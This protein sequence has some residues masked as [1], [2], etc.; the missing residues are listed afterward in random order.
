MDVANLILLPRPR[1]VTPGEG[2]FLFKKGMSIACP[3]RPEALRHVALILQSDI[4]ELTGIDTALAD[5]EAPRNPVGQIVFKLLSRDRVPAQGYRIQIAP[6][7]VTIEASYETGA[8]YA[9]MTLR[10][11]LRQCGGELPGLM[12][13]DYPDFPSRGVML[14]ISRDRVPTMDTLYQLVDTLA[15]LKINHLELYTEHTFAYRNHREVW[16]QSSPMTADEIRGLDYYCHKRFIEL[17]PNQNSF[18]HLHRW[19]KHPKYRDLAECPDGFVTPWSETRRDPFSLNPLDPRS[20]ELVKELFSELLPN[21]TSRRFN[22]GC[23]ETFDLGQGRSKDECDK[24]G[25]GRVYVDF[26]LK[27]YE[28]VRENNRTMHFWGDIVLKHKALIPAL[29]NDLVALVWGY[30]ADHPFDAQCPKFVEASIPFFVCPGTSTWNAIAGRTDNM[31]ANMREATEQGIRHG[32]IGCLI[33][34]WGDN[35]HWQPLPVSY[36]PY[37]IGAAYSWGIKANR[38]SDLLPAIDMHVFRDRAGVMAAAARDLGNAYLHVDFPIHNASALFK[39][40]HQSSIADLLDKIPEGRLP[41]AREHIEDA[42]SRMHKA[43]IQRKDADA[44]RDEFSLAANMM[45]H[46]CARGTATL[47]GK[48]KEPKTRAVLTD[49]LTKILTEFHRLW[50]TRS[51]AGGLPDSLKV[52][53]QRLVEYR[54]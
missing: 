31:L 19:L 34:D 15:E 10:Q 38:D 30:E 24:R 37:S 3:T 33:T 12:M 28:L 4:R 20:I 45:L 7:N 44:I 16:A 23:D 36:L 1:L 18:G 39:L 35:G 25:K 48:I 51:R 43:D 9:V 52:L 54:S 6:K 49:D 46:A 41:V 53:G 26:L 8:F 11:I 50:L 40:L 29:P 32:A 13:H 42:A 27:I 17:V 2:A 21:F 47:E 22:V 5:P 14:D